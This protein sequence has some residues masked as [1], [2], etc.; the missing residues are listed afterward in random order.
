MKIF[1]AFI[2]KEFWHVLRDIRSLVILLGLP[3]F[4]I[5]IF[6]FALSTEVKDSSVAILDFSGDDVSRELIARL[7]ASR[8]FQVTHRLERFS[9]L[10]TL[11]KENKV[12]LGIIFN[13]HLQDDLFGEGEASIQIIGNAVDPNTTNTSM[14]YVQNIVGDYQREIWGEMEIPYQIDVDYRMLYNPQLESSYTFVPGVMMLILMLLGAMMT[15]VSIV[16][17]K[18]MGTMEVLLVSPM[19]PFIVVISKAVPY[20]VLCF[21]DVLIILGLAYTVMG[22]PLRG[23]LPLLL[24]MSTLFII[25]TLSLGLLISNLVDS[26]QVAMFLS[27]VGFLM[28]ALVFGGFMFPI[29][30]MP[31]VLQVISHVVPTR[32]FFVILKNIMVKGLGFS[33]I[34][35]EAMILT[36]MTIF[37]LVVATKKFK[38]RLA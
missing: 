10:E 31:E 26:Q 15:S 16:R 23:S 17:E 18:E 25:T 3:V 29:E 32:W 2:Q 37:F 30:N 36:G 9:E 11:F 35:K 34:Y 19:K 1:I 38:T 5:L 33:Y 7:D 27:L 6:G 20:L 22:M 13:P 28:P 4:M 8:Y 14:Q 21:I 12:R 24:G